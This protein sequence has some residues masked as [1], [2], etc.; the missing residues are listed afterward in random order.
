MTTPHIA[1]AAP[2]RVLESSL[3]E[4]FRKIVRLKLG[5]KVIKLAP[6]ERGIPDRLVILPAGRMRLVE[7]KTV[8]GRLSPAQEHV[9]GQ[10]AELGTPVDVLYGRDQIDQWVHRQFPTQ[11]EVDRWAKTQPKAPRYKR[12]AA[13]SSLTDTSTKN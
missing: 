3:E 2:R 11:K 9:I 1:P 4:Y 8:T 12:P 7:L 13:R 6:T 5:G 10:L